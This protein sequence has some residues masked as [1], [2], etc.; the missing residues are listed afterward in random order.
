MKKWIV[1]LFCFSCKPKEVDLMLID[2]LTGGRE[3]EWKLAEFSLDGTDI[4]ADCNRDD[5]AVFSKI[6]PDSLKTSPVFEYRKNALLCDV[7]SPVEYREFSVSESKQ[8]LVF[9]AYEEWQIEYLDHSEL[10]LFRADGLRK[11]RY[12]AIP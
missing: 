3:K 12:E 1:V 10:I 8:M 2:K 11:I 7:E 9:D 4:L 6:N 5:T